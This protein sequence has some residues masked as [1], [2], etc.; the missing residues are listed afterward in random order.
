MAEENGETTKKSSE[1]LFASNT[2]AKRG[3][4]RAAT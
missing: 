1:L 2:T 3:A 4:A